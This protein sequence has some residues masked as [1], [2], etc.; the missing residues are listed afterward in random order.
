MSMEGISSLS[1]FLNFFKDLTFL[2]QMSCPPH[3]G[4]FLD[5]SFQDIV[6]G[7]FSITSFSTYLSLVYRK[8]TDFFKLLFGYHESL[9]KVSIIYSCQVTLV[10]FLYIVW[11]SVCKE[12][13]STSFPYGYALEFPSIS[14]QAGLQALYREAVGIVSCPV[15]FLILR[16]CFV[17][18]HLG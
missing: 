18:S 2:L 5:V 7:S 12:D 14:L 1:V 9:L 4:L 3:L 6:N 11:Y 16:Y 10:G 8:V 17:F 15:S 13:G